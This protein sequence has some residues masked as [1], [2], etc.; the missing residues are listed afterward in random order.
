MHWGGEND[1]IRCGYSEVKNEHPHKHL[2]TIT[3]SAHE[4]PSGFF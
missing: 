4:L 3:A 1:V 2:S